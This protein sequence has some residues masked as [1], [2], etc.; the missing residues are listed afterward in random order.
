[1][2]DA[3][4]VDSAV[5][6][7]LAS[8]SALQ[9]LCPD[10]VYWD[11]APA[12]ASAFVI[13]TLFDHDDTGGIHDADLYERTIYQVKAV[14]EAT[15]GTVARDAAARIHTLL[16]RAALDLTDAGY[17]A[18][19]CQRTRRLRYTEQDPV[20]PAVR[21]Q[22]R[23]GHYEVMA[24]PIVT[25]PIP[26]EPSY[27]DQVIA[28]GAVAYWRLGEAGG[29]IAI[30]S[31]G[32]AH[33]TISGGVTLNQPGALADGNTAMLFN[34]TTGRII[35]PNGAYAAFGTAPFSIELWFKATNFD[36]RYI[37]DNKNLGD[38][39]RKGFNFYLNTATDMTCRVGNGAAI[40]YAGIVFPQ[41]TAWHHVVVTGG[42]GTAPLRPYVDGVAG[43]I[44]DVVTGDVS[45]VDPLR[46]G[47]HASA[48][49]SDPNSFQGTLDEIA[50]YHIAL[51]PAQIADHYTRRTL[52]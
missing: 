42:G 3:S 2:A 34:G 5:L 30:D 44:G 10:G 15:G 18:M 46:I 13:V 16:H 36:T 48:G 17:T 23:G 8:D 39:T 29:T 1:M 14:I 33:G 49:A 41:D 12:G 4:L 47:T 7:V 37:F 11:L 52:P 51:T 32:F 28:D 24:D 31:V 25:P 20:E 21:W 43:A 27:R 6:N 45:S 26:P 38:T 9:A 40:F 19:V 50:I 22:H 35:V